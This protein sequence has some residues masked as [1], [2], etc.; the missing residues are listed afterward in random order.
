MIGLVKQNI[1]LSR[2]LD[3]TTYCS[4]TTT[5]TRTSKLFWYCS[6]RTAQLLWYCLARRLL[7]RILVQELGADWEGSAKQPSLVLLVTSL[8]SNGQVGSSNLGL[9]L[10]RMGS[11]T[12]AAKVCY[13]DVSLS[14]ACEKRGRESKIKIHLSKSKCTH[15]IREGAQS[16]F[17]F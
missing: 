14:L 17:I 2:W 5:I 11:S 1:T 10:P 9:W 4:I 13:S 16:I 12:A 3:S 7:T 6:A 8:P 15:K